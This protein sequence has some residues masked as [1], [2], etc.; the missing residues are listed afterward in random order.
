[1]LKDPLGKFASYKQNS[2]R[3][4]RRW[5]ELCERY[6]PLTL[7]DSIWRYQHAYDSHQPTQGW[8]LHISATVLNACQALERIAPFLTARSIHFKAP[9]SLN[10]LVK[11]N[12]GLFYGYSQVGKIITVYPR[13]PEEAVSLA[14]ELH[15]MTRRM[16]APPVPFDLR[17]S[18]T[19]NVYYRY[20][21]FQHLEM[22][23]A[24]G[25]RSLAI[26]DINGNLIPDE[27]VS[28]KAMPDWVSDPFEGQRPRSK[29]SK[30]QN[31]LGISFRVFRALVQRGKGGVYQAVDVRS[32]PPRLCLLKEGR[33]N[34]ELSW[35]GRDGAW[36]V[37][38]EERVISTLLASGVDAPRIY[39]SFEL[40]GNYY[41]VTEFIN[42]ESLQN[43]LFKF[44]R[45]MPLSRVLRYGIQLSN[46]FRHIHAAGW[47]WRDCKPVN[48]LV[49]PEGKLRPL[50]FE[51]AC[52]ANQPDPMFWGTPGFTPP[53]WRESNAQ[54]CIHDDL[55]ALGSMLYL[56]LTGRVPEA[57]TPLPIKKLRRHVPTKVQE[58]VMRLLSGSPELRPSAEMTGRELKAALSFSESGKPSRRQVSVQQVNQRDTF[59]QRNRRGVEQSARRRRPNA[60][61][62]PMAVTEG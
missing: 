23:N 31:P 39:S 19:S 50:D 14:R 33:K 2:Q 55:Y 17:Y 28:E 54:T 30:A 49:T 40:D 24:N 18:A 37:R 5:Q 60:P 8:K 59:R 52:P 51:G 11:I 29:T 42:G 3:L 26:K 53:D 22:E 32:S 58:L 56:L 44:Q 45:R 57:T 61:V 34:G 35:D 38:H 6:L 12:S 48:I 4:E 10:E 25:Q 15:K 9:R 41:L 16:A 21:G 43:L 7:K 47:V 1:M 13:T 20:G 27:R 62:I 36:R 46:I